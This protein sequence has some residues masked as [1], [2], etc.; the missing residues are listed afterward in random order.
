MLRVITDSGS[1]AIGE[2][3]LA[4]HKTKI[5]AIISV[6]DSIAAIS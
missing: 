2:P 3:A 1:R 6:N 5:P 4:S